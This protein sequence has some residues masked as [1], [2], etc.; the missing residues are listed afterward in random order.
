MTEQEQIMIQEALRQGPRGAQHESRLAITDRGFR[1]QEIQMPVLLWHG[2]ADKNDPV[3]MGRYMADA[4]QNS[5]ARF[6]PN[7]GHL[8]LYK[9]KV[10][11]IIRTLVN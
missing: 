1:P 7:E 3:L 2:E 4:I 9:K 11:E 6:Y 5:Q 10:E 8:S